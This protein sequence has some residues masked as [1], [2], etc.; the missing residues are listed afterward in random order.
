[1]STPLG[2]K[3]LFLFTPFQDLDL[4]D[5]PAESH[6]A[7]LVVCFRPAQLHITEALV[8]DLGKGVEGDSEFVVAHLR[9]PFLGSDLFHVSNSNTPVSDVNTPGQKKVLLS[10]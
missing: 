5:L 7:K 3:V 2:K 6:G 9:V 1:M 10:L 4:F 8:E